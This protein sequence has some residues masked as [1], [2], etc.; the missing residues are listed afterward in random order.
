MRELRA[1]GRHRRRLI[2]Q[3]TQAQNRSRAVP[4]AHNPF[5]RGGEAVG[6]INRT[7]CEGLDPRGGEKEVVQCKRYIEHSVA[8]RSCAT[9]TPSEKLEVRHSL[10]VIRSVAAERFSVHAC[11]PV[12]MSSAPIAVRLSYEV[13]APQAPSR[14]GLTNSLRYQE[15]SSG[16][17]DGLVKTMQ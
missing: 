12:R 8:S 1:L 4:L 16:G 6:P 7:W 9:F 17:S 13:A 15:M 14:P 5:P 3:R 2:K 11:S 10:T